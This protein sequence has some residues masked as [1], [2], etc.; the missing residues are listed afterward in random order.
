ML[1]RR[2]VALAGRLCQVGVPVG[3]VGKIGADRFA[4]AINLAVELAIAALARYES[5]RGGIL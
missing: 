2:L 5:F 1:E 4:L 3:D